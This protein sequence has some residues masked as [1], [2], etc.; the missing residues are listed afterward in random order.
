MRTSLDAFLV[1]EGKFHPQYFSEQPVGTCKSEKRNHVESSR[2]KLRLE[3]GV[4]LGQE[5]QSRTR[6]DPILGERE[7]AVGGD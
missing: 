2:R 7:P 5:G 6:G 1:G 4:C 3:R